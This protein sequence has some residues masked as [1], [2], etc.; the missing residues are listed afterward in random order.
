MEKTQNAN[1]SLHSVVWHNSPKGKYIGQKSLDCS[2]ALA[3]TIFNEDSLSLAAVLK[4]Y[5][6]VASATTLQHLARMD[7]T[8]SLKRE[9]AILETQK[10]RRRQLKLR[11]ETAEHFL[12]RREKAA[13]K[14]CSGKFGTERKSKPTSSTAEDSGDESGTICAKCD[15]GVCQIGRQRKVN[16]WIGCDL[17]E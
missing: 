14:Y 16:D 9:R 1:E 7:K 11:I 17:C 6:V 5:G 12:R 13:S 15:K 4:E 10:R 3:L 2:T 8:R